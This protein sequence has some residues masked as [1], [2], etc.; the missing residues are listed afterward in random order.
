MEI[1]FSLKCSLCVF[2]NLAVKDIYLLVIINHSAVELACGH[3]LSAAHTLAVINNCLV[4]GKRDGM[5]GA[6]LHAESAAA[7]LLHVYMRFGCIVHLLF[8]GHTAATHSEVLQ[9]ASESCHFMSL[10]VVYG[11]YYIGFSNGCTDLGSRA[12]L[13]FDRNLHVIQSLESVSYDYLGACAERCVAVFH[14]GILMVKSIGPPS[15]VKGI[16]VCKEGLAAKF[17]DYPDY[18]GGIIR[19]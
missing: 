10:H 8:A 16:A 19:P 17:L 6:V 15:G 2:G 3:A 11:Y 13:A 14:G 9:R 5:T 12:I 1:G 4:P 18:N 7:T